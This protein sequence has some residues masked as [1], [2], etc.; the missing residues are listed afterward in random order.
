MVHSITKGINLSNNG[1]ISL[2]ESPVLLSQ[3]AAHTSH[4]DRI[5]VF[6]FKMAI[7]KSLVFALAALSPLFEMSLADDSSSSLVLPRAACTKPTRRKE[8]G[9]A[10]AAEKK[11]Y[12]NAVLCLATKPSIIG[13]TGTSLY[14]DFAF[15][16]NA[17][18]LR[19][20]V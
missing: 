14:D 1:Y 18:N 2:L 11:S 17:L 10:T 13:H 20:K 5:L 12:T 4:T 9:S 8:W 3:S 15:V 16:H 19:S 7:L 6:Y